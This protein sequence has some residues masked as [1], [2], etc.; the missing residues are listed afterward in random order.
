MARS[1]DI[2]TERLLITPLGKEHISSKYLG[3]LND[4]DLMRYSEQ[5]HRNHN[6]QSCLEYLRSFEDSPHHLWAIIEQQDGL[7]HVGNINAYVNEQNLLADI[8]IVIGERNAQGRGYALEAWR[9]VSAYLFD[10][11][12]IRKISAGTLA[13]NT[14]M[15][16]LMRQAGMVEDGIRKRHFLCDGQEMDVVHMALFIPGCIQTKTA[17]ANEQRRDSK[18]K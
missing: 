13:A 4:K 8:G 1:E 10:K 3:W 5:R 16:K 12:G 17:K 2:V 18:Y 9:A 15:L 7:G 11:V 14:P 6:S